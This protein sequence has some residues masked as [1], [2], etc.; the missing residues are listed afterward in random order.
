MPA[1][2][3]G[4][5]RLKARIDDGT[6]KFIAKF[7]ATNDAHSV[8]EAEFIAMKLASA[9]G[10]NA[11]SVSMARAAH[12]DVLLIERFDRVAQRTIHSDDCH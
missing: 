6:K 8:V 9:C 1:P 12:R 5:A 10:L 2:N 4:G 11:A 3:L 7:S